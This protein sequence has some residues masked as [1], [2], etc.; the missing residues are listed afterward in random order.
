MLHLLT[1]QAD[2]GANVWQ[3]GK[4]QNAIALAFLKR[5]LIKSQKV[6][7][8]A[9]SLVWVELLLGHSVG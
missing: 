8:P 1:Q 7:N 5:L 9:F 6:L 3:A 4:L 2:V